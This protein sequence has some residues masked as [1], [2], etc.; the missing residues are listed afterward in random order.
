[1]FRIRRCRYIKFRNLTTLTADGS[2]NAFF[3]TPITCA[4]AGISILIQA[5]DIDSC[6]KSNLL[7]ETL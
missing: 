4:A 6:T 5:V 1:M 3:Y 7:M 2:G